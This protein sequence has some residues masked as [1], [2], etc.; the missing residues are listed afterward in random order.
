MSVI[1]FFIKHCNTFSLQFVRNI[2]SS[3]RNKSLLNA[4][5]VI[6]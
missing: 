2:L 5:E 3:I 4:R 1:E 6:L